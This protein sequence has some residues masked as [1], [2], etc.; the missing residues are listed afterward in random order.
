[1]LYV[2]GMI[3]EAEAR[4]CVG[5]ASGVRPSNDDGANALAAHAWLDANCFVSACDDDS[6]AMTPTGL[7]VR[8]VND[9]VLARRDST[10]GLE[11]EPARA[12]AAEHR[13]RRAERVGWLAGLAG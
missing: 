5:A 2:R 12:I 3:D 4:R 1:M 9:S 13:W 7:R 11:R 8:L 6:R 10:S